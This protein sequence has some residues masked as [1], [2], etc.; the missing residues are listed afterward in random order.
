MMQTTT[1]IFVIL[2]MQLAKA[3]KWSKI[4]VIDVF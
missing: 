2:P 4:T 3:P 1:K